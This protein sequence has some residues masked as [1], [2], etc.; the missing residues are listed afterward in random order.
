[1]EKGERDTEERE[2]EY[3]EKLREGEKMKKRRGRDIERK[4]NK[5]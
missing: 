4:L 1:M 3:R 2:R 5:Q